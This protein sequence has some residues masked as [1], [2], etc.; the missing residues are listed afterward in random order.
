ML[1]DYELKLSRVYLAGALGSVVGGV[2]G[3][4]LQLGWSV[5]N[6]GGV[7]PDQLAQ[8]RIQIVGFSIL[9]SIV[10]LIGLAT[11]GAPGWLIMHRLGRRRWFDAMALGAV[12]AFAAYF[13]LSYLPLV[14][15]GQG[16]DYSSEDGGVPT[17]E[18][19]RLTAQGWRFLIEGALIQAVAGAAAGVT[20]WRISYRRIVN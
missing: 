8:I 4:V 17:V 5:V 6:S 14:F 9:A 18:H 11:L 20:I 10:F 3:T 13:A 15:H 12:L 1:P 7:E 16:S 19:Y 2:L